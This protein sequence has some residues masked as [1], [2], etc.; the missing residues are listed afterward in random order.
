MEVVMTLTQF[1]SMTLKINAYEKNIVLIIFSLL[2]VPAFSQLTAEQR[3]QDSVIGWWND[4]YWDRNWK[5]QTD[6]VGKRKKSTL[7][8]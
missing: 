1:L 3:I 4:N 2:T 8:I 6:P 7:K 5:P